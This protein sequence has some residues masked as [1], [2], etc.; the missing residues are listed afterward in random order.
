M[1]FFSSWIPRHCIK[2]CFSRETCSFSWPRIPLTKSLRINFLPS[3]SCSPSECLNLPSLRTCTPPLATWTYQSSVFLMS[4]WA[5]GLY[6]TVKLLI[7]MITSMLAWSTLW[8]SEPSIQNNKEE[9]TNTNFFKCLFLMFYCL[10]YYNCP[11]LPLHTPPPSP[12]PTSTVNPH[13]VVHVHG[14]FRYV[15]CLVPSPS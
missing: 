14:S 5:L 9:L 6:Q 15:L 1:I 2:N 3:F 7:L 8:H 4:Y 13:T 12:L 11:I 10:C